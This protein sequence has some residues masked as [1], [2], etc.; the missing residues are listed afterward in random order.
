M[1]VPEAGYGMDAS[2]LAITLE[3]DATRWEL[4]LCFRLP[5]GGEGPAGP[6]PL[7]FTADDLA[8]CE[9]ALELN[10]SAHP[11]ADFTAPEIARLGGWGLLRQPS[12]PPGP[13]ALSGQDLHRERLRAQVQGWLVHLLLDPLAAPIQAL[14]AVQR[15]KAERERPLLYLRLELWPTDLT[16][17]RLPWELL[18]GYRLPQGDLL[19]GRYIRYEQAAGLPPPA[20]R[21]QVLVLHSE[22]KDLPPLVLQDRARIAAGLAGTAG[23]ARMPIQALDP[24]SLEGLQEALLALG[25]TPTILHFA[26]HGDFGWRCEQCR[27]ISHGL[28]DTPCGRADCGF[29][30]HGPPEGLLAFTDPATGEPDWVGIDG[31]SDT[32]KLAGD[33][34]LVVLTA[35]KSAAGRRG[36]D[37]FNGLA[38][39]LMDL[40]PAVIASPFPLETGAAESFAGS[41][42]AALGA[43]LSLVEAL[44]QV[45]LRMKPRFPDEWYRPVLYLRSSQGDG[46]RLLQMEDD[47]PVVGDPPADP[48]HPLLAMLQAQYE[49]A[50][51]Q[52]VTAVDAV[53]QVKAQQQADKVERDMQR[54]KHALKRNR[55]GA[56]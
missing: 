27:G 39:R 42:Y 54:L 29:R 8:L 31:V 17:F 22:P 50:I 37:V 44:H 20:P 15:A 52:S 33:L 24:A 7:P 48:P 56:Q 45:H 9:R 30:R 18:H 28:D 19:V 36:A 16:L 34:R 49:A 47:T 53:T 21:L 40:V 5:D 2:V 1:S 55:G 12:N 14:F 46:G 6:L 43:G 25:A 35:C 51:E 41:L 10:H 4:R 13:A 23:A 38:Q 32:L 11:R 26:G 3:L